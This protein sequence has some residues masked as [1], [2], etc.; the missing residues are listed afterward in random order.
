MYPCTVG[1]NTTSVAPGIVANERS[2][3][4]FNVAVM[5]EHAVPNSLSKNDMVVDEIDMITDSVASATVN[6]DTGEGMREEHAIPVCRDN[7]MPSLSSNVVS[8]TEVQM[9]AAPTSGENDVPNS[10]SNAAFKV[11]EIPMVVEAEHPLILTGER[12][13][14]FTYLASLLVK[15]AGRKEK[16]PFIQG[17]IKVPYSFAFLVGSV[18]F[19]VSVRF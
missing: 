6:N 16:E 7:A 1:T 2:M 18:N 11:E 14:P 12:E 9:V 13:I 19:S 4:E 17:K 3:E 10:S 5:R 8:V 15:W